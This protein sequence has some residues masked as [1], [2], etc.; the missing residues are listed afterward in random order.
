[1]NFTH[2]KT[3]TGKRKRID[4]P[5]AS[6]FDENASS[7]FNQEKFSDF[8]FIV[9]GKS[10]HVHKLIL[11]SRCDHFDLMFESGMRES[12][13]DSLVIED[14]S[15]NQ[16]LSALQVIYTGSCE[17]S[18]TNAVELLEI[19]NFYKLVCFLLLIFEIVRNSFF[20]FSLLSLLLGMDEV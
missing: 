2:N 1:M 7:L 19:A 11:R 16:V 10:I 6:G 3:F 14:F 5:K 12:A 4:V 8:T 17:V 9:E 18:P 13:S 20:F 15:Y